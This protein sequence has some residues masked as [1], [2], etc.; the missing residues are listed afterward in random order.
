M[1]AIVQGPLG[2]HITNV[3]YKEY[4][5]FADMLNVT[6]LFF[7]CGVFLS[8]ISVTLFNRRLTDLASRN[9]RITHNVFLGILSF[10]LLF[11]IFGISFSQ[12]PAGVYYSYEK[13]G[14]D[15]AKIHQINAEQL[16]D[17]FLYMSVV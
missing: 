2:R 17:A 13:R 11:T 15:I 5:Q 1:W 7:Y 10:I 4:G 3:T 16:N 9:W 14:R 12:L 6:G 8:A